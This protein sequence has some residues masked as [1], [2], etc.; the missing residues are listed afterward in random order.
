MNTAELEIWL[1]AYGRAWESRDP[2][3]ASELFAEQIRYYETPFAEPAVGR[4]GVSEYWASATH[5]QRD[6]FFS[7]EVVTLAA[8]TGV[9]RWSAELTRAASGCRRMLDGVFLLRFDD[10]GL[11]TELREWWH[12]SGSE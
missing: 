2:R 5:G 4:Q 8:N 11:C 1:Q 9:V 3:A 12:S 10:A 6:V 7:F